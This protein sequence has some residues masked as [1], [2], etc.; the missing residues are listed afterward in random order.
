MYKTLK[1]MLENAEQGNQKE[2][3]KLQASF[4]TLIP[5]VYHNP[6]TKL[7][8]LYENCMQSCVMAETNLHMRK[9][10]LKDA[11]ERF[12]KIPKPE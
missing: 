3:L 4:E 2:V 6:L 5:K 7:D 9:K 10:F 1:D 8:L 11:T 12:S